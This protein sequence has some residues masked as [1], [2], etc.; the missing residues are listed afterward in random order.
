M[1]RYYKKGIAIFLVVVLALSL[2]LGAAA[3]PAELPEGGTSAS[4]VFND[5]TR[6]SWYYDDVYEMVAAGY[7][8]GYPDGSF[9]GDSSI[10][11]AELVTMV[12]RLMGLP[13]GE[14][15]GHYAGVQMEAAV[16]AGWLSSQEGA[17]SQY[18]EPASRELAAK[19][20]AVALGLP[21]R[22]ES[23][24]PF[25]DASQ[26][27][28]RY[29]TYVQ[30]MYETGL[31]EGYPDG[32]LRP[33]EY[34]SRGMVATLLVRALD[35]PVFAERNNPY[36]VQ[37]I[38]DFFSSTALGAEYGDA[39]PYVTKWTQP[40]Y[41]QY[42]GDY[43]QEDIDRLEELIDAF[44]SIPGFPGIY[45]ATAAHAANLTINFCDQDTMDYA[46]GEYIPGNWGFARIW[47]RSYEVIQ[48]EVY[49]LSTLSQEDR[50][51]VLAE[52][53]YQV[54]GIL[55]DTYDYPDSIIYQY[56]TASTWPTTLDWI[57]LKTLYNTRITPGMDESACRQVIQDLYA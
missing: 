27:G 43:T 20:I 5:L 15:D 38:G 4:V 16:A 35:L 39:S 11:V 34:V 18:D 41:Y 23:Q 28:S 9:R 17:R 49:Y 51:P 47:W 14:I 32:S 1:K 19:V 29:L 2:Q 36:G 52:E 26:V 56:Y 7:L 21:A 40:I 57:N 3:A 45:P 50:N 42:T 12:T 13:E 10:S 53:L 37:E 8:K 54:L 30:S 44:Q 25:T 55:N 24:L 22:E 31:Y 33:Q 6:A 48:G 46:G